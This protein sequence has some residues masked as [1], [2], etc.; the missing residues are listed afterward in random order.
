MYVIV[1]DPNTEAAYV[2]STL[3]ET[4]E[5]AKAYMADYAPGRDTGTWR[6]SKLVTQ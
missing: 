5:D 1:L 6:I 4:F 2:V 3:F